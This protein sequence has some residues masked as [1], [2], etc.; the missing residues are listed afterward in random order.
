MDTEKWPCEELADPLPTLFRSIQQG[1][2][3]LVPSVQRKRP[4][5]IPGCTSPVL[6]CTNAVD[7]S[8]LVCLYIENSKEKQRFDSDHRLGLSFSSVPSLYLCVCCLIRLR[9]DL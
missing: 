9:H 8:I 4:K 2:V 6:V 5:E 1:A 7:P 3:S